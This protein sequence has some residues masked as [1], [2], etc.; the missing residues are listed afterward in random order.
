MSWLL[1]HRLPNACSGLVWWVP[2]EETQ[3][4][5]ARKTD[6]ESLNSLNGSTR[7]LTLRMESDEGCVPH[8]SEAEPFAHYEWDDDAPAARNYAA[9]GELLAQGD[10][11]YRHPRHG[12]GL[13]LVLADGKHYVVRTGVDLAPIIVDRVN[14]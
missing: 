12:G 14:V 4:T 9:M 5:T 3:M 6:D 7:H 1:R 8:T 10:D 2:Q 11:L 13:V